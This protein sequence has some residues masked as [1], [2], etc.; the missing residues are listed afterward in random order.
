MHWETVLRTM[1]QDGI[2]VFV[3]VG[4]GKT[5]TGL[6]KKTFPDAE[7]YTVNDTASLQETVRALA[8]A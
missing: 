4:P 2:E 6:V 1:R 8:D 3:E 5:L 7:V